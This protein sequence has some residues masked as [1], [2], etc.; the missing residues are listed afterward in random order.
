LPI[1]GQAGIDAAGRRPA[2]EVRPRVSDCS[3]ATLTDLDECRSLVELPPFRQGRRLP[4][5]ELGSG[6][7]IEKLIDLAARQFCMALGETINNSARNLVGQG[8]EIEV[9]RV[10]LHGSASIWMERNPA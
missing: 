9:L 8:V 6:D 3:A 5:E 1:S 4:A 2:E 10:K 7:F